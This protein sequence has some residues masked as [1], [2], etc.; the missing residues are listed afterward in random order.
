MLGSLCILVG[1]ILLAFVCSLLLVTSLLFALGLSLSWFVV[2]LAGLMAA[3]FG[4]WVAG[5]YFKT[6]RTYAFFLAFGISLVAFSVFALLNSE[7]YEASWDGETYHA[8]AIVQLTNGWNPFRQ[9]PPGEAVFPTYLSFFPKG[10]WIWAAAL[11][12]FSG[13][14]ESGKAFHLTLI[15]TCFLFSFGALDSLQKISR[16]WILWLSL[17]MAINPVSASQ[18]FTYYVDGQLSSLLVIATGLFILMDRRPDRILTV[19]LAMVVIL[20]I[21][22]KLTGALYIAIMAAGYAIWYLGAKRERRFELA[23][24]LIGAGLVGGILVGFNPYITQFFDKF[25]TT[26]NPFDPYANWRSVIVV[27]SD[28]IFPSHMGH[29]ERL[30]VS[31][32]SKSEITP[33]IRL[34][35]PFTFSSEEIES[36]GFPDVRIG[37]LGPLF[38]GALLLSLAVLGLLFW[39][40]RGQL[41]E[42]VGLFVVT[43]LI[44]LS[45]LSFSEAWWAR[46]APQI[47]MLPVAVTVMG[48]LIIH[49]GGKQAAL[50]HALLISLSVNSM[51][52]CLPY[53]LSTYRQHLRTADQLAVFKSQTEPVPVTLNNFAGIRYRF[54]REGV[55]YVE[56]ESLPCAK[57][58]QMRV[59]R[60]GAFVCVR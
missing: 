52:I 15:L 9:A 17:L 55:R 58:K 26:G 31:I 38:G 16:R 34:K 33:S 14:F 29:I 56:V 47:W 24:W 44:V 46:F 22:V 10:P 4:S 36:F 5:Q 50:I 6:S 2:P 20:T 51:L 53:L 23:F 21:N 11:Y 39:K 57:D 48:I 42:T 45:A 12:K 37:G 1:S 27:E 60:T 30:L 40:Y 19:A 28:T 7:I 18:M 25:I 13:S 59:A 3:A 35:V 49:T 32:F 41:Q 8:E 54:Q 43:G